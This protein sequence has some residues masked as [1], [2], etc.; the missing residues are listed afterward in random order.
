MHCI[1]AQNKQGWWVENMQMIF[2]LMLQH[3]TPEVKTKLLGMDSCE[4][5]SL[6][7]GGIKLLMMIHNVCHKKDGDVITILD[8]VH[9]DKSVYLYDQSAAQGL[10]GFLQEL[11][12]HV[13]VVEPTGGA[14]SCNAKAINIVLK[15]MHPAMDYSTLT[16]TSPKFKKVAAKA[17]S[18][19]F[20]VML[21]NVH[22]NEVHKDLKNKCT[23]MHSWAMTVSSRP[24]ERC[25]SLPISTKPPSG[26]C[27]GEGVALAVSPASGLAKWVLRRNLGPLSLG[28]RRN[29]SQHLASRISG[30][31]APQQQGQEQV[32]QL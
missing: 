32:F 2:N 9:M 13:D 5:T 12:C 20:A 16:H 29:L 10:L 27:R 26:V 21:F 22:I 14:P 3:M 15:L 11:K 1:S 8:L 24:T 7:Q 25:S 19:Y 23:M 4:R 17:Q 28:V 30:G 31:Y 18:Q 6:T